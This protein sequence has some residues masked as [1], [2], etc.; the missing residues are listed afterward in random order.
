MANATWPEV[1]IKIGGKTLCVDVDSGANFSVINKDFYTQLNLP[2]LEPSKHQ[3]INSVSGGRYL[4]NG[5]VTTS[6]V[7]ENREIIHTFLVA[8][9][10]MSRILL[11]A[12]RLR[13]ES[14]CYVD[15]D[16]TG[17]PKVEFA[18]YQ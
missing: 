8:D 10:P 17:Y 6:L 2:H 14:G 12:V 9:T 11:G 16:E 5:Q 18:S 4:V 7:I 15:W 1:K 13:C 3:Y